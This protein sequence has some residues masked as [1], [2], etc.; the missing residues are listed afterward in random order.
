MTQPVLSALAGRQ[1]GLLIANGEGTSGQALMT[2]FREEGFTVWL[3]SDGEQALDLYSRH[4]NDIDAVLL[5]VRLAKMDGPK[6]LAKLQ[7][8]NPRVR[9]FFMSSDIGKNTLKG[10]RALG[11]AGVLMKPFSLPFVA[12]LLTPS[13]KRSD[14]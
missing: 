2:G 4:S 8:V 11:A 6:T 10:L 9:C 3:A 12:K 13:A 7:Q 5:D 1:N 14:A